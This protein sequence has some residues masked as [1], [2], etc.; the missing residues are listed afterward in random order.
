MPDIVRMR[1]LID[2]EEDLDL[3]RVKE[4]FEEIAVG[5]DTRSGRCVEE[6]VREERADVVVED[7]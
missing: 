5:A 4:A 3:V 7:V 1:D 6:F 2:E